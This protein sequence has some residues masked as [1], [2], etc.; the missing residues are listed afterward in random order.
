[1]KKKKFEKKSEFKCDRIL[2]IHNDSYK[3]FKKRFCRVYNTQQRDVLAVE[4]HQANA[5]H[6]T[7]TAYD[8][9]MDKHTTIL[10]QH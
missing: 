3:L 4:R 6:I 7:Q 5:R 9:S 10:L 2:N 8:K 1:M